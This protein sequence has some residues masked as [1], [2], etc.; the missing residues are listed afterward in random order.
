METTRLDF[1]TVFD[2]VVDSFC[3]TVVGLGRTYTHRGRGPDASGQTSGQ[4]TDV[5]AV[6]VG[7]RGADTRKRAE[8]S[9]LFRVFR[10]IMMF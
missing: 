10:M 9:S 3:D 8:H 4:M 7:D 1:V 5:P 2:I 6:S